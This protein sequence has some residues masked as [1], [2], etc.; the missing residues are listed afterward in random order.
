MFESSSDLDLALSDLII[1]NLSKAITERGVASLV[2]SGGL[3]SVLRNLSEHDLDWGNVFVTV[4]NDRCVFPVDETS[5]VF[6]VQQYLQQNLASEVNVIPLYIQGE[7]QRACQH[8]LVNHRV[9]CETYDLVILGLGC[10]GH[11]AA[12]FP[13][14]IER[15]QA[16][17][18]KSAANVLLTNPV[19]S[20]P[21]QV[22]QTLRRLLNSR[23][24]ALKFTGSE[25]MEVFERAMA[26]LDNELTVSHVLHQAEVPVTVFA[27]S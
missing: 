20:R 22:T 16:L 9:L 19:T 26:K 1:S 11:T 13:E 23:N 15:D 14:A 8:R 24:I 21:V 3:N 25:K 27:A 17:N 5:H 12:I 18:L 10:D 4:A 7:S 6:C 2:V